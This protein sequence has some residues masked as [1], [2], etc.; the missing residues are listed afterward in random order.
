LGVSFAIIQHGTRINAVA[1]EIVNIARE[2]GQSL[3][4]VVEAVDNVL[5]TVK[6]KEKEE[7]E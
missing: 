6:P 4:D 7:D 5:E 2:Y 3:E 1:A